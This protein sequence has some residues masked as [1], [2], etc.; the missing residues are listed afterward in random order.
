MVRRL[1]GFDVRAAFHELRGRRS[2]SDLNDRSSMGQV[3]SQAG[4][5][6][7]DELTQRSRYR[8]VSEWLR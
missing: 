2:R 1:Y 3:I 6:S 7:I 8:V 5:G 4:E